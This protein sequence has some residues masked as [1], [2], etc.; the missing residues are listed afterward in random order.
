[1]TK[2]ILVVDDDT[3]LRV[4][5]QKSLES[6]GYT[7]SVAADGESAL[8]VLHK[9]SFDL[10]ITDLSMP[11]M[12]GIELLQ[13][14]RKAY[15]NLGCLVVTAY[16]SIEKAVMAMQ[17]GAFDFITKPFSLA[18]LENC[19]ERFFDFDG[20][21]QENRNLKRE[22]SLQKN[23]RKMVGKSKAVEEVFHLI[24][25][26]ARA[27]ATVFVCGPSGTGK[28]LVAQAVHEGS[29]RA[30]RPFLKVNCAAVPESL[31]ESTLFGHLKGAFSG[32]YKDQKGLFEECDGGTLLLDEISEIP[33]ALQAKLLRVLQE[34]ALTRVG[35]TQEIPVDVRIVATSNRD[36][37]EMINRGEFREDLY[38]RLNV[39]PIQLPSLRE[40][41]GDLPL[42][43]NH[44]LQSFAAK[45]EQPVK[46]LSPEALELLLNYHWPGNI[47]ELEHTLERAVLLTGKEE[48]IAA[49]HISLNRGLGQG[50]GDIATEEN[51]VLTLADM[52]R[53]LILAAMK[54]TNN[55]RARAASLLGI[56]VRTLRNKLNLY[57]DHFETL[58]E[59]AG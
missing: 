32:A 15:P 7:V 27:D 26:V 19:I 22:L 41:E 47:R 10:M 36:I 28:E 34:N 14:A 48:R 4:I 44:F 1:M 17:E 51:G 23:R 25:M 12:S 3:N 16:G 56:S 37:E 57:A 13:E 53:K 42:L 43:I 38:F 50:G 58:G 9:E 59:P 8:E 52:E 18:H 24:D 21:Q 40:R 35:S 45:Y 5:L 30:D 46:E 6:C 33:F 31:F 55:H 11:G 2:R 29:N 54:K 39:F 20:L 49:R